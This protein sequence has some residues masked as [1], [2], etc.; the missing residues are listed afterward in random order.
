MLAFSYNAD[1][2]VLKK[3]N[4]TFQ[5]GKVNRLEGANG[6]GKST[7]VNLIMGLYQP[8]K[9]E[10]LINNK[11]K[12]SEINLIKWR[13]KIAYAEHD[14]LVENG[15]STGQKQLVDLDKIFA[16]S[17]NKEI[18]IFDEADNALDENNKKNFEE[19]IERIS[20]KKLVILISH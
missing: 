12:L 15:L 18:F 7:I 19:K 10:I 6:F 5:K 13:E 9:G 4:L 8:N 20:K 1:K 14:N 16:T 11:Y 2:L 3:F 17:Q